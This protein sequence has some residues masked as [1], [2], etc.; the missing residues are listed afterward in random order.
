[1]IK[2]MLRMF[3][4]SDLIFYELG[5]MRLAKNPITGT[6]SHCF[7]SLIYI[8]LNRFLDHPVHQDP[9]DE[10]EKNDKGEPE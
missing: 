7:L 8:R 10:G 9:H 4:S 6:L 5:F 2:M 3:L 1:M